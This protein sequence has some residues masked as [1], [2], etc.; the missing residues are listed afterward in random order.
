MVDFNKLTESDR[1]K[2]SYRDAG[3]ELTNQSVEID[4]AVEGSFSPSGLRTAFKITTMNVTDTASAMPASPLTDRNALVI[5]NLDTLETLY[6]GNSGVTADRTL[7]T[8]AGY[9]IQPGSFF[10]FD[11]TDDIIIYGIAESGKTIKIKVL[12]IA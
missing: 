12:E 8:D 2:R 3:N 9:E 7:G 1:H 4:G 5:H 11:I 10:N 6:L